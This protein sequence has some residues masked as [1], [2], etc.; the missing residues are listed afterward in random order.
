M[1]STFF[2][3]NIG[4]SALSTYQVAIN[5]TNNNISNVRTEGYSRQE[6]VR[7]TTDALRVGAKYGSCGTG[8][9]ATEIRQTRDLYYDD[10]YRN[11]NSKVGF[12]EQS[13][14]YLDQY[15]T[16]FQDDDVQQGFTSILSNMFTALDTLKNDSEDRSV[17]NQ[18]IN[19]SQKLC[20][21]FNNVSESLHNMQDDCNQE[22]KL[23]VN[24]INAI[25]KKISM[26]N[27]EINTIEVRGGHANELRDKRANLLDEL[28]GFVSVDTVEHEITN[29]NGENLGGTHFTVTVNGQVL[30]DGNDARQMKCVEREFKHNQ[31]DIDGLY[32]IIWEDTKMRFAAA[33]TS[34]DGS[35]KALFQVRDGNAANNMKG[36]VIDAAPQTI[37]KNADGEDV[38]T[39]GGF[40]KIGSLT[41]TDIDKLDLPEKGEILVAS[42][43][44]T[45]DS[46]SAEINDKGEIVNMT[47]NLTPKTGNS[48][49]MEKSSDPAVPDQPFIKG[50]MLECGSTVDFMGCAYYQE[51]MNEFLREFTERINDMERRG[52]TLDGDNMG[53][54]FVAE[55]PTGV[56]YEGDKWKAD[57]ETITGDDGKP[58]GVYKYP[59]E[60]GSD[61]DNYTITSDM[62]T[63][64]QLMASNIRVNLNSIKDPGYFATASRKIV[65]GKLTK[66]K[67][68]VDGEAAS[69]LLVEMEKLHSDVKFFRG[70]SGNKF[71]EVIISDVTVDTQKKKVFYDNYSNLNSTIDTVRMSISGVDEDEEALNLIK[72]QNAYNLASKVISVM[73]EMYNKLINE[74]GVA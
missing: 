66:E 19:A 9:E 26:L 6:A 23:T 61:T 11:N 54:F 17:R 43:Y 46:W 50:K 27:R 44:Y 38:I 55:T 39:D 67:S 56:L 52:I 47:F 40:I 34:S 48:V 70:T 73:S 29:S 22:I 49:L 74:T 14:Y 35:L 36:E 7:E 72:F 59:W 51:Q 37:E 69:D 68:M 53:A 32:D 15:E 24:Q 10:K 28:S 62:D 20:T 21:Y 4:A 13:I 2:G 5:T 71:L 16:I 31:S 18:F 30:V 58:Q 8:V 3:L 41:V 60:D 45:Y 33:S 12:Y 63:Y 42:K 64:H 65:D 25:G 57:F 1:P